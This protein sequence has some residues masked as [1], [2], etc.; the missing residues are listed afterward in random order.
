MND[1]MNGSVAVSCLAIG[2]MTS[3]AAYFVFGVSAVTATLLFLPAKALARDIINNDGVGIVRSALVLAAFP[4]IP[5]L[6]DRAY[7]L[8][9]SKCEGVER[10]REAL[11]SNAFAARVVL[12]IAAMF[13]LH[14]I[15]GIIAGITGGITFPNRLHKVMQKAIDLIGSFLMLLAGIA[16]VRSFDENVMRLSPVVK[17]IVALG[18]GG[19][20]ALAI[21]RILS[22]EYYSHASAKRGARSAG[23]TRLKTTPDTKLRDVVGMDE[24]K[25]QIKL[26]MIEPLKNPGKAARYGL[27]VGGGVLLYGPPGTG[28]TMLARGIAGELGLPFYMI[29]AADVFGKYVGESEKNIRAIFSEIRKNALSVVFIDELETLFPSRDKDV[30]ETTR[31][32]ISVILQELDGLDQS[33]NPVL[34]VGATNVPWMVD[35]AFLRPGRFDV[36]IFVGLPGREARVKMIAKALSKGS[37]RGE[38]ELAEYIADNTKNYSGA[39]LNGIA[40]RMRQV[41]YARSASAYTRAIADEAIAA[42]K[43]TANGALMDQIHDWEA[44]VSGGSAMVKKRAEGSVAAT[45][46]AP[47]EK[48]VT[49]KDVAGM[50]DVKK[51]IQLRLLEPLRNATL[52]RHY[53]IT[54]G[55]GMLLYGPPGTGKT[56]IARAVAGELDLPFYMITS[57]DIFGKYVGDAERNVKRIFRDIRKNDLSV[58]FIDEL[59]TLF[60]KRTE[61]VHETTR[62]VISMLLQELDGLDDEKN[63]MLLIGA[64]NVPWMVDE[65][66]LRPGRFDVKV[67]VGLPDFEARRYIIDRAINKGEVRYEE[68]IDAHIA[69]KTEG[70]SGADMKGVFEKMRQAAFYRRLPYYTKALA[71][72]ILAT[73]TSSASG[74]ILAGIAE[75]E[76]RQNGQRLDI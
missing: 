46:G 22:K 42:V 27:K 69:S 25:E 5:A 12:S 48:R 24:A 39:D 53:G 23:T 10:A 67:F 19:V 40:D 45:A 34:L 56:L 66:F 41:A 74:E 54:A 4:L 49:L 20:F 36:K 8:I 57:A 47:R 30:H 61:N 9:L 26:R 63:P 52:A 51:Q 15:A 44:Q 62:K 35:E 50:E 17:I 73:C 2:L 38:S 29:T 55:G 14:T 3:L 33:K 68:G 32:V 6:S 11:S 43:P 21:R 31:K 7:E 64:T 16:L 71:D 13:I 28:K 76:K 72:E 59:E 37:I 70:F 60:P 18:I 58:V 75:W 65:A 1:E